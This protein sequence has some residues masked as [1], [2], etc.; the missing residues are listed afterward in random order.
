MIMNQKIKKNNPNIIQKEKTSKKA[1]IATRNQILLKSFIFINIIIPILSNTY[2][3]IFHFSNISLKI[4]GKGNK[5]IFTSSSEF[6]N[7]LY[8]NMIYINNEIQNEIRSQYYL[9]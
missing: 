9:N 1:I 8:P 4:K 6:D 3:I 2:F 7:E 5:N